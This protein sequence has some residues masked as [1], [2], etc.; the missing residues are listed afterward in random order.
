MK[1]VHH[2]WRLRERAGV[3]SVRRYRCTRCRV[4][5]WAKMFQQRGEA[6]RIRAYRTRDGGPPRKPPIVTVWPRDKGRG[7]EGDY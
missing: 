7:P 5:G 2:K 1:C 6:L 4:W 3:E